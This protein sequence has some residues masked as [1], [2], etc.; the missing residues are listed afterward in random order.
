MGKSWERKKAEG[1][2]P[3][4][5]CAPHSRHVPSTGTLSCS[6]C[7]RERH[8][9]CKPA[10]HPSP[11]KCP[12][13]NQNQLL[14]RVSIWREHGSAANRSMRFLQPLYFHCKISVPFTVSPFLN[15]NKC[16]GPGQCCLVVRVCQP[17]HRRLSLA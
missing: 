12:N 3:S 15:V 8:G 4:V 7:R 10:S 11:P 9:M 5:L 1:R 14:P 13:R 2:L 17:A 16:G 6:W